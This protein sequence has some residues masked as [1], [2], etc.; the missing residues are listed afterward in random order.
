MDKEL[1]NTNLSGWS[2]R[3]M[4]RRT[5]VIASV[6][7]AV[8]TVFSKKSCMADSR[9]GAGLTGSQ[10]L[11]RV[12]AVLEVNGEI[13]LKS[14][15]SETTVRNGKT[16][17]AKSV[18]IKATSTIDF[19]EHFETERNFSRCRSYQ[20]FHEANSEIQ[21]DRHVTK[22]TLREQ[23]RDIVRLGTDQ[24]ILTTCPD[25]PIFAAER[26]LIDGPINT[27]FMEELL[28]DSEVNIA[29]K[30]S[31][32]SEA[33]CRLLN[34]DAIHDGK[35]IVCLVD[36]DSKIAQLEI[37]GSVSA[38][39]R[40][41]PTSIQVEGKAQLDRKSGTISWL[42]VNLDETR[43]ISEAEP[44]FHVIAQVKILRA[45]IE[46]MTSGLTL[47]KVAS[48]IGNVEYASLLQFQ[49]DQGYYRFLASRKWST[50]RDNGEE[51]TLRYVV[52]NRVVSQCNVINMI[53]FEPGRQLS[54]DGFLADVK[55][56]LGD[57]LQ[58]VV[59]SSERLSSNKLRLLKV[60]SRG[61]INGVDIR[62]IHYHISNDSGRRVVLTF[63]L[64]EANMEAFAEEDAQLSGSFELI[65]W[66]TK[67]DA[68]SVEA[69]ANA[70]EPKKGSDKL[71][72]QPGT[73]TS[74]QMSRPKLAR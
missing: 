1:K 3:A 32:S 50:Y 40:Q 17:A 24:G 29:D 33:A 35:L 25:N 31:L 61:G 66:P 18:P 41:V 65:N 43:E 49:S 39:V 73:K 58:E 64:D 72:V 46:A 7:A 63:T 52:N 23:C 11:F 68:K 28:T 45:P 10:G 15:L 62:W 47:D 38:S 4:S 27:M 8:S 44:G 54:L 30:W 56:A 55:K 37:S 20:H 21:I 5:W 19:D 12:R 42:A 59:E 53:D 6:A 67:L 2:E 70:G 16:I 51:A 74:E 48:R 36:A 13:R 14:Q 71:I 26:D 60:V 9:A 22:T 57:S 34:L 69:A